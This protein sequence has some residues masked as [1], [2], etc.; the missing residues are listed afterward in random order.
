MGEKKLF[1][2]KL[3]KKQLKDILNDSNEDVDSIM[4]KLEQAEKDLEK[5]GG[6]FV[7]GRYKV[8]KN[9]IKFIE[10]K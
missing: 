9:N 1:K 5:Q 10:D 2:E 8:N 7:F 6:V 3:T 4:F